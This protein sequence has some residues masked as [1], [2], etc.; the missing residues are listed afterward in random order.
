MKKIQ[1]ISILVFAVAIFTGI[2]W[3][4]AL[5][6]AQD[7]Y[8]NPNLLELENMMYENGQR[9]LRI[10]IDSAIKQAGLAEEERLIFEYVALC[11]YS[12]SNTGKIMGLSKRQV[13]YKYNGIIERIINVL[14]SKGIENIGDLL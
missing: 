9:D 7:N 1:I 2:F 10:I 4:A 11:G 6:V 8:I 12:Y 14:K 3:G 13:G 5:A